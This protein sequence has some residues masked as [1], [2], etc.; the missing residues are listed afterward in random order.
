MEASK[1]KRLDVF[2][3]EGTAPSRRASRDAGDLSLPRNPPYNLWDGG[4]T[5]HRAAGTRTRNREA[6]TQPQL[7][8]QHEQ[9]RDALSKGTNPAFDVNAA[10]IPKRLGRRAMSERASSLLQNYSCRENGAAVGN[11]TQK[12]HQSQRCSVSPVMLVVL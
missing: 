4:L 6:S 11:F 3:W 2:V 12:Q 5:T 9:A 10:Y 8:I 1:W 7:T